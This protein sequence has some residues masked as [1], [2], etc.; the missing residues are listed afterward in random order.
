MVTLRPYQE[1]AI[2]EIRRKFQSG[3]TR[4]CL[5]APTGAGK[6]TIAAELIKRTIAN[7]KRVLFMAHRTELIEQCASR[8]DMF[9]VPLG[10]IKS[11]TRRAN[12][13]A[14]VQVASVQTLIRR[15]L[16][17]SN[18]IIIDEC[19]R[20]M[21]R[22]YLDILGNYPEARVVGLTATPIRLDGKGLDDVFQGIVEASKVSSLID[23]RVLVK[24][25]IFG[26][27]SPD[28]NGIK[29]TAGDFNQKQLAE[30]M[31]K[32]GLVG[33]IV[34]TYIKK[35]IGRRAVC[36]ATSVEH[37]LHIVDMLK[38]NGIEAEHLDGETPS[39]QR[40]MTLK[41]LA[42]GAIQVVSNVNVLTEGWDCPNVEVVILARPTASL[43]MYLQMVGRGVRTSPGKDRAIILDHA[44]NTIRHGFAHEDRDW[45]KFWK[46]MP[47]RSA[48]ERELSVK[49][50]TSCYCVVESGVTVCPECGAEMTAASKAKREVKVASGELVEYDDAL[51]H[52]VC[53]FCQTT[54]RPDDDLLC[55][56]CK[57]PVNFKNY[58]KPFVPKDFKSPTQEERQ[59]WYDHCVSLAS[60]KGYN[61]GWVSHQY[62]RMFGVW[63]RGLDKSRSPN[64]AN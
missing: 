29:M 14:P 58:M 39:E 11:G 4:V 49:T 25:T 42:D 20:V 61:P 32:Q 53:E 27:S 15:D 33:S 55:R 50:C 7:G 46:G 56:S 45:Q 36:F 43:S 3:D 17:E 19:H 1:F 28:L 44:G 16:P 22:T 34:E 52:K 38:R 30:L 54:N 64:Y 62:R 23:E 37:S 47:K 24:P 2:D 57:A 8:L 35:A 21:G 5:V 18:L 9:G 60:Q 59:R 41:R 63:P 31:D 51:F 40:A 48:E 6:T 13:K 10:I 12:L 26:P